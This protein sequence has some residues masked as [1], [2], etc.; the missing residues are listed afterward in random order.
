[1]G[2]VVGVDSGALELHHVLSAQIRTLPGW[3]DF[4]MEK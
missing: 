1:M 4:V 2:D 3:P